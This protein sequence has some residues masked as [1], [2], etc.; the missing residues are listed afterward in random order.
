MGRSVKGSNRGVLAS[1]Y[2]SLTLGDGQSKGVK[3][4]SYYDEVCEALVFLVCP[5]RFVSISISAAVFMFVS[6]YPAISR[7]LVCFFDGE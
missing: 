5:T 7:N 4:R 6:L 1:S 2:N 3:A